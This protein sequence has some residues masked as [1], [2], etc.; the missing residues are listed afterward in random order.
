MAEV[1]ITGEELTHIDINQVDSM[2]LKD[3]T[4]IGVNSE[5]NDEEGAIK[6]GPPEKLILC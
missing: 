6:I 2:Q 4:G 5:S 1:E 3:G